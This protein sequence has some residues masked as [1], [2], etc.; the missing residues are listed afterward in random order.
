M[1]T[2]K[3]EAVRSAVTR[4]PNLGARTIARK[5]HADNKGLFPCY[6]AAYS[7]VRRALGVHGE[8]SRKLCSDKSSFRE[9]R[10][11][12]VDHFDDIPDP[13]MESWEPL[14]ITGPAKALVISDVHVPFHDPV[15]LKV[16]LREG[17]KRGADTVILNG[18]ITDCHDQSKF[19]KNPMDR[20]FP[21]EIKTMRIL[22]GAIRQEFK[23]A[24]IIY[25]LGNHEERYI[26]YFMR[27]APILLDIPDFNF[28]EI[29]H[30]NKFGIEMVADQR[31]ISFGPLDIMHAHE[32]RITG[33][34]PAD[35]MLQVAKSHCLGGHNHKSGQAS[36]RTLTGH[37]ISTWSTGCLCQLT[38]RYLRFNDWNH[39]FAF[40]ELDRQNAFQ[41]HNFRIFDG[42][43]YQ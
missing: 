43:V 5:V 14:V 18:D 1:S 21:E 30:L 28:E 31:R 13:I 16:A 41:V 29:M 37:V 15:A 42:Q 23:K 34:N 40:P 39:G 27:Q 8:Y 22:L 4:F 38:P 20:I 7:A 32:L 10:G 12:H 36:S 24:R 6:D 19:D 9:A 33:R 17:K 26:K 2:L 11:F 25:K 35:K 3:Q